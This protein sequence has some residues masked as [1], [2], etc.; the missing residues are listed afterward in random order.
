MDKTLSG[1]RQKWGA[2]LQAL[3]LCWRRLILGDSEVFS[4]AIQLWTLEGSWRRFLGYFSFGFSRGH[5]PA[6]GPHFAEYCNLGSL[7]FLSNYSGRLPRCSQVQQAT[8]VFG[9]PRPVSCPHFDFSPSSTRRLTFSGIP[10]FLGVRPIAFR[11]SSRRI[12]CRLPQLFRLPPSIRP[13]P[14]PILLSSWP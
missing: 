10:V 2:A 4:P 5:L 12:G 1:L 14:E 13:E 8:V 11:R 9:R 7:E 3:R 6:E